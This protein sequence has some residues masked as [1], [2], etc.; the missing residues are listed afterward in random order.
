MQ[1]LFGRGQFRH[2]K[3]DKIK[4]IDFA[5]QSNG[6]KSFADLGGVW[7]INGGYTFYG[8]DKHKIKTAFLIDTDITQEVLEKSKKYRGLTIINANFGDKNVVQQIGTVDAIILFDV[9]LHQVNP[10]WDEILELYAPATK[11]FIVYNQQF[12][13]ADKTVRLFDLG[14]DEY[15]KNVPRK[16]DNP[17]YREV[18][19]KMYELH[20]QHKRI[21]RDIHNVWQWGIVDNDLLAKMKE[22]GF[23]LQYY[24][25]CGQFYNLKNFENHAFVFKKV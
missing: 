20:P 24:K 3:L 14:Y 25:N 1:Y 5:F 9:L 12:I 15:F 11:S 2:L 6:I 17:L 4:L 21:W 13:A 18:F 10:D 22:L 7:G 8:M 16:K 23:T 19:E